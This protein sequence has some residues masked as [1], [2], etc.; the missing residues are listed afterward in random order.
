MDFYPEL[1]LKT[2]PFWPFYRVLSHHS[3]IAEYVFVKYEQRGCLSG[4]DLL[5]MTSTPPQREK[6]ASSGVLAIT[7]VEDFLHFLSL[8]I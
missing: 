4:V 6:I 1:V 5:T 7:N 3:F 8:A 2:L